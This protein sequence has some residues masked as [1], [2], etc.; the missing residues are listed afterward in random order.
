MSASG[1]ATPR[2][3]LS[4]A[5]SA[6]GGLLAF[7]TQLHVAL[8][9][10]RTY[11]AGHPMVVRSEELALAALHTVLHTRS[12]FT[13]GVARH[14]LMLNG[15]AMPSAM[16]VTKELAARLHRRGV[17]ALTFHDGV[18]LLRLQALLAWL[19]NE[20]VKDADGNVQPDEL[21]MI[22]GIIIG[23]LAYDALM[24]DDAEKVADASMAALW[25]ALAQIASD[26]T[27]RQ[28]G[29]GTSRNSEV[30]A[31]VGDDE[32]AFNTMLREE[33]QV[34]DIAHSL[35]QIV[36][37]P[38]FAR[39]TAVA[40]MNLAAQG[41]QAPPELRSRIGKRLSDVIERLGDSS[42]APIIRGLGKRAEQQEFVLQVVDVL[43]VLAV[44]NWLQ[45]AARA[46][47]QELSHHLVRLMM[48][49]SQH[50]VQKREGLTDATFRSAAKEL[51]EG[52]GLSDPNPEEHVRLLD[53]IALVNEVH[54]A[55]PDDLP[56]HEESG[57]SEA[58]RLVQMALEIDV[59]G[60]DTFAAV[61]ALSASGALPFMLHWLDDAGL[62]DAARAIRARIMSPDA[63]KSVLQQNPVDHDAAR[64]LLG[65]IDITMADTLLEALSEAESRDARELI[66]ERLR[67]FGEPLRA[68]LISRLDGASWFFAR[69]LLNLLRDLLAEQKGTNDV[70]VMLKF[71]DHENTQVRMVAVR[72]MLD[73][74][75]VRDAA[76]RRGL[77]DHDPQVVETVLDFIDRYL[78]VPHEGRPHQLSSGAANHLMR[79]VDT[80][81]HSMPLR[82]IAIRAAATTAL[83][84]VRDWLL[85]RVLTRST[86]LRRQVLAKPSLL[87]ATALSALQRYYSTDPAVQHVLALGKA[88]R[89][90][91]HWRAPAPAPISAESA[92]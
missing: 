28:Y 85:D 71:L 30:A 74:D 32:A 79:F 50:A 91:A 45:V 41:A 92:R 33:E 8:N 26:G 13:I 1:T 31:A 15:Q 76:I 83:P 80:G 3:S 72:M 48:K 2:S 12:T 55:L 10:R 60:E 18:D 6:D 17:G 61:D 68:K 81:S 5:P 11:G 44:S 53:Q 88:V 82:V 59:V 57:I 52:W 90:N 65:T 62:T 87:N 89:G 84:A 46:S 35:Q 27:G 7:L 29:F 56:V 42:F 34:N 51:V 4:V 67:T 54:R 49:L 16:S 75:A 77:Q 20:P 40:L 70:G 86:F 43:P 58:A 69:N 37:Q 66:L 9:R 78:H 23:R 22:T 21:P 63:V 25:Q 73:V 19:A 64:A 38:E 14:E 39:R 47:E 36:S 24:L